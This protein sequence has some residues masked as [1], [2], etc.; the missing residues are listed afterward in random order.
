MAVS[1]PRMRKWTLKEPQMVGEFGI[2]R[3]LRHK[4]E[5]PDGAPKRDVHT[6]LSGDWCNVIP[7][8]PDNRVVFIWQHRFGSDSL[9]LEVP[10][11]VIDT[12]E[13]PE[14]AALRELE[15][16]SGY[17]VA[18]SDIELLSVL[19]PNPALFGNR[20][21]SY[22]ARN[23]TP[24]GRTHFDDLEE[25]ETVLVPVTELPALLDAGKIAHA[26]CAVALETFLR[27][28]RDGGRYL[29]PSSASF[30]A[31]AFTR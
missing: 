27:R 23:V 29:G 17:Q 9:S 2:F 5:S 30:A 3:V 28:L 1:L 21:F 16:E 8:T 4:L 18:S 26:L 20:I 15:E 10:G 11:G 12:G 24:T 31:S 7:V 22:V 25:C 13:A 19:E 6:F 14:A